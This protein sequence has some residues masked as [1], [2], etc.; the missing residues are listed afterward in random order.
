MHIEDYLL[1]STVVGILAQRL[2][3][4]LCKTCKAPAKLGEEWR[5]EADA[6]GF[7]SGNVGAFAAKGCPAC[8]GTGY[9]GR[10][11][12]A[13]L[14]IPDESTRRMIVDRAGASQIH[15][16]AVAR[17]MES[18]RRNG[19]RRVLEGVTSIEEVSRVAYEEG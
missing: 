13:E 12:I 2:V 16:A 4:V 3:R 11:V 8:H 9:R 17:G 19:L 18:L 15:A 6:L 14:L 5:R 7:D 10:T 1:S